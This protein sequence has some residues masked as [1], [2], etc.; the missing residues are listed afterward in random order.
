MTGRKNF[1]NENIIEKIAKKIYKTIWTLG[2]KQGQ[3]KIHELEVKNKRQRSKI[4][5]LQKG[6][7]NDRI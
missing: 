2:Y 5:S 7:K 3:S 1:I 4:R 6:N